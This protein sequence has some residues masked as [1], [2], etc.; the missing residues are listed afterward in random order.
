MCKR[1]ERLYDLAH[2][3]FSLLGYAAGGQSRPKLKE[4]MKII[5]RSLVVSVVLLTSFSAFAEQGGMK[6]ELMK[7][8]TNKDGM[9][10]KEESTKHHDEKFMKMDKD[11]NGMLDASEQK[12]MMED[13]K[14]KMKHMDDDSM[15]KGKM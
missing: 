13:M 5:A 7:C 9:I 6:E 15:E 11:N 8:D 10:S 2:T 1:R 3:V 12:M 14:M 4:H